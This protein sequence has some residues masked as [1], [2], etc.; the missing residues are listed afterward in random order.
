MKEKTKKTN[1]E[2][3][4]IN[5]NMRNVFGNDLISFTKNTYYQELK[6]FLEDDNKRV[7]F[8][9][10]SYIPQYKETNHYSAKV[11]E[12][13]KMPTS[14]ENFVM[15][16]SRVF[17]YEMINADTYEN[18][19]YSGREIET[20][21]FGLYSRNSK[22]FYA[23]SYEAQNCLGLDIVFSFKDKD[24]Y[25]DWYISL[26]G[27]TEA[28]LNTFINNEICAH[29]EK[30]VFPDVKSIDDY[31][32]KKFNK[33]IEVSL[34]IINEDVKKY[35]INN[36]E[37]TIQDFILCFFDNKIKPFDII[38]QMEYP[39]K[40]IT[41]LFSRLNI[42]KTP[43]FSSLKSYY[44]V[45]DKLKKGNVPLSLDDFL[46]KEIIMATSKI[47][48]KNVKLEII[49]KQENFAYMAD[50]EYIEKNV[51]QCFYS[52]YPKFFLDTINGFYLNS[53]QLFNFTKPIHEKYS[54]N[55]HVAIDDLRLNDIISISFRNK[56]I[57]SLIDSTK[58]YEEMNK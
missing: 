51:N 54:R 19:F 13:T 37:P 15:I 40:F 22:R 33:K 14:I 2:I 39:E 9:I 58:K 52:S 7:S 45:K 20:E 30:D 38:Y 24:I 32:E 17:N 31:F 47:D 35:V 21:V 8:W 56:K 27:Y 3:A 12:L 41:K 5:Q 57:Y 4:E 55:I 29:L 44:I 25:P 16:Y 28:G 6:K 11:F 49:C 36:S 42:S 46:K 48:A 23:I 53:F 26:T 1:E 10:N 18:V 43:F 50:K 34:K